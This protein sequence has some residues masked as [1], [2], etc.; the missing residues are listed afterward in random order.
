MKAS[1]L[2]TCALALLIGH[3]VTAVAA[4]SNRL[5]PAPVKGPAALT[6]L[7]TTTADQ[8]GAD[9]DKK[10]RAAACKNL[11]QGLTRRVLPVGD[12][13]FK[14]GRC[15]WI[16]VK[17]LAGA[18]KK[19]GWYA[20]LRLDEVPP[21]L[22]L[23]WRPAAKADLVDLATVPLPKLDI[24]TL[25][26]SSDVLKHAGSLALSSSPIAALLDIAKLKKDSEQPLTLKSVGRKAS[27][28]P[29]SVRVYALAWQ[30]QAKEW[31]PRVYADLTFEDGTY[32]GVWQ[33]QLPAK[34]RYVFVHDTAGPAAAAAVW[35]E[36]LD[37]AVIASESRLNSLVTARSSLPRGMAL[38]DDYG[39][40]GVRLGQQLASGSELIADA[41]YLGVY[42]EATGGYIGGLRLSFELVPQV[43][44]QIDNQQQEFGWSRYALGYTFGFNIGYL[45]DR[46]ELTPRASMWAL[47]VVVP[48][49]DSADAVPEDF[50]V[51][52]Q[53]SQGISVAIISL[54]GD[55]MVKPYYARDIEMPFSALKVGSSVVQTTTVGGDIY[56]SRPSWRI[57]GRPIGVLAFAMGEKIS[58]VKGGQ[59][60]DDIQRRILI[61]D[62]F[63]GM[64][65]LMA[66]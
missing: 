57:G 54:F 5:D 39:H 14:P 24:E 33:R 42:L 51:D 46:I 23:T 32:Q 11:T 64:G 18:Q 61:E 22:A 63:A 60:E 21:H 40:V 44:V 29:A 66:L 50:V 10:A 43:A 6:I 35:R 15:Q 20:T 59:D 48:Y 26:A 41:K 19:A 55:F 56:Y 30:P 49:E 62:L 25:M 31:D 53:I 58:I 38:I 8:V 36:R 9:T 4:P 52:N 37:A 2:T 16:D 45:I 34:T 1:A 47:K 28:Q 3:G 17:A 13:T 12:P 7:V 27:Y 65:L